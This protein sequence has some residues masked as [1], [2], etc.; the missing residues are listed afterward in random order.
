MPENT[1]CQSSE[2]VKG[3][4]KAKERLS[5]LL[6]ANAEGTHRLPAAV[7]GKFRNPRPLKNLMHKLPVKYYHNSTAWFT[8]EIF[9]DW[10][11]TQFVPSVR[12]YQE[13]N[14]NT[15]PEDVR[16]LLLVDNAS[17]HPTGDLLSTADGKIKVMFLPANTTSLVQ[18]MDQG[19]IHTCKRLYR[20]K[21]MEDVLVVVD[22]DSEEADEDQRGELTLQRI[23]N[24]SIKDAIYNLADSWKEVSKETL[25]NC[26]HKLLK[27]ADAP[28]PDF[29]GFQA[30]DLVSI[31]RH[32]RLLKITEADVQDWV[33]VDADDDGC[34]DQTLDEIAADVSTSSS[35]VTEAEEEEEEEEEEDP[36]EARRNIKLSK[37]RRLLDEML[38]AVDAVDT[39][40]LP[41]Q[42][43]YCQVRTYRRAVIGRQQSLARQPKISDYFVKSTPAST[44]ACTPEPGPS[45]AVASTSTADPDV[46]STA[47]PDVTII[48]ASPSSPVAG[49][50][51]ETDPDG[52]LQEVFSPIPALDQFL[53][54]VMD[55][56]D[57]QFPRSSSRA[58]DS[59][60]SV[61]TE[62][63]S[64]TPEPPE[65]IFEAGDEEDGTPRAS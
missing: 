35:T 39:Q 2:T 14:L 45:P 8:G 6:C 28:R 41:S 29:R 21:Q 46:M 56:D 37:L 3:R 4:K 50:S 48:A 60:A 10:F 47:D 16:A 38:I 25:R 62:L 12:K 53:D 49:P 42:T 64:L 27:P 18:P 22:E 63:P 58:S 24:Y 65:D 52:T 7:V 1:F 31:A 15:Q 44:P 30:G 51:M 23:R 17:C 57:L 36:E 5:I 11:D 32:A 34:Q 26:W 40:E 20:K 54:E 13:Q 19:I 61:S 33:D 55:T 9:Q 43:F 59:V